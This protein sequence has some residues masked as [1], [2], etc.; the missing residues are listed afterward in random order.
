MHGLED[1]GGHTLPSG[2]PLR[3]TLKSLD[4]FLDTLHL[5]DQADKLL[6]ITAAFQ[7]VNKKNSLVNQMKEPDP[8]GYDTCTLKV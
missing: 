8:T 6:V 4:P 2:A 5:P 3:C 1:P 7:Q